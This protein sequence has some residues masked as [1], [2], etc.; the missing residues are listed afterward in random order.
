M[1]TSCTQRLEDKIVKVDLS[2]LTL[3]HDRLARARREEGSGEVGR[4][5]QKWS[6]RVKRRRER[7]SRRKSKRKEVGQRRGG[8]KKWWW[9]VE[10]KRGRQGEGARLGARERSQVG[11]QEKSENSNGHNKK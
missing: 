3:K 5:K 10:E 11:R 6:R 8:G 2:L 7:E 9:G 1:V 4:E